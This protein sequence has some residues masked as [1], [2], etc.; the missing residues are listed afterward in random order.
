MRKHKILEARAYEQGRE[1]R[2]SEEVRVLEGLWK[3]TQGLRD[4]IVGHGSDL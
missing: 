3:K 2:D 4:S 1:A